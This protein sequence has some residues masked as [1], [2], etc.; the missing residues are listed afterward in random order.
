MRPTARE[1]GNA[2]VSHIVSPHF[3]GGTPRRILWHLVAT[4]LYQLYFLFMIC[5]IVAVGVV[6]VIAD[7]I[8]TTQI[9][10]IFG[11][12]GVS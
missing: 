6:G 5:C 9:S 1:N 4:I 8:A 11:V 12:R 3:Y 10:I 7:F 2:C